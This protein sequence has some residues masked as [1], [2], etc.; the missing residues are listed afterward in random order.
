MSQRDDLLAGARKCLIEK[1]YSAT[2]ARD[3]V[4]A[5]GGAH[6]G[7]IGYHFGSKDALM[8][9]AVMDAASEWGD[10]V[11]AAVRSAT[12]DETADQRFETLIT[13]LLAAIPE[14]RPLLIASIQA[15]AQAQF[16][17]AMREKLAA[18]Y[19][20]ARTAFASMLLGQTPDSVDDA[21]VRGLGSAIYAMV[22][23]YIVQAM[24]DP[25]SMPDAQDV[26]AGIRMLM[27]SD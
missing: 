21:A 4:A 1:G 6:L 20:E 13:A 14:D 11:E 23:G 7:S 8:N 27:P 5:S 18:G 16:D 2:T 12:D 22:T 15:F 9:T 25:D 24:I 10:T 19:G 17:P 3:I 26:V